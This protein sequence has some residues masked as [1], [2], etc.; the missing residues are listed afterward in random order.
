MYYANMLHY[1]LVY[2]YMM[3]VYILLG[4]MAI[5]TSFPIVKG[6]TLEIVSLD[7]Q[8]QCLGGQPCKPAT[9]K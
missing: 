5:K 3:Y 7:I 6:L 8:E 9:V 2:M 1:E 4:Y